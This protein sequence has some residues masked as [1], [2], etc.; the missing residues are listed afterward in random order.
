[1][2]AGRTSEA[3]SAADKAAG[4]DRKRYAWLYEDED[5]WGAEGADGVPPVSRGDD[6][7]GPRG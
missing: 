4:R 5:I 7:P 1:M 6:Q 2:G 3:D